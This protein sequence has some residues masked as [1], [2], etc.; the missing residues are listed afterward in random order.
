[1]SNYCLSLIVL[2]VCFLVMVGLNIWQAKQIFKL[3]GEQFNAHLILN[4]TLKKIEL[5]DNV[6]KEKTTPKIDLKSTVEVEGVKGRVT[7]ITKDQD[8][9][10][11]PE[12]VIVVSGQ[13][14]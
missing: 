13:K 10:E 3:K 9:D 6:L 1:M 12:V 11:F 14:R 4:H 7:R 5:I 2:F 8:E